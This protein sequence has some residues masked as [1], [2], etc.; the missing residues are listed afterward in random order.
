MTIRPL[1]DRILAKR[2][3]EEDKTSGGLFIP[4]SAR[5]KSL[6]ALVISVGSGKRLAN[7][8]VQPLSLKAGD[9]I[10]IAKYSEAD[11]SLAGKDHIV[12]REDDVL[13]V[14]EDASP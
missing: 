12:V 5:Q 4:D 10:L 11:V 1:H 6:E 8:S 3:V 13:A 9:K 7:G 2:L 14:L